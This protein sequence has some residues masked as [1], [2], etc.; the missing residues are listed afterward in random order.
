MSPP[1]CTALVLAAGLGTRMGSLVDRIPKPLLPVSGRTLLD[2]AIDRALEAGMKR[3]V[4][5]VH[6]HADRI[7]A[8]LARRGDVA[9]S[10]SIERQLLETGG[11]ARKALP[12]IGGDAFLALNPDAV[13]T[14][15]APLDPLLRA[16]A[17]SGDE[18][19]AALLL[20][21]LSRCV[22][23]ARRGDFLLG[24]GGALLRAKGEPDALLYT[25]AQIV[26]SDAL[27]EAPAGAWSFNVW[28]DGV[29][30][31]RICGVPSEAGA[32]IDVGTPAGLEEANRR[33]PPA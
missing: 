8:H 12:L 10:I 31:G 18:L 25:G 23:P 30:C 29:A 11:G 24:P 16:W 1:P 20:R 33:L 15:D 4:V 14:G 21:P 5:N 22:T 7:R 27:R 13:W 6:A 2:R 3:I 32:W 17:A 9:S 19:D 26:R 28:W